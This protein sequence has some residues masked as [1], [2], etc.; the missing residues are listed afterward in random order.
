MNYLG[1]NGNSQDNQGQM[2]AEEISEKE[3]NS[4]LRNLTLRSS[5]TQYLKKLR[6]KRRRIRNYFGGVEGINEIRVTVLKLRNIVGIKVQATSRLGKAGVKSTESFIT[7]KRIVTESEAFCYGLI[8]PLQL[9]LHGV[10]TLVYYDKRLCYEPDKISDPLF[11]ELKKEFK[12]LQFIPVEKGRHLKELKER[13]RSVNP[14]EVVDGYLGK[15][16][17][18]LDLERGDESPFKESPFL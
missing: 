17:V 15:I 12:S 16:R 4:P 3:L 6:I 5:D 9:M 10:K 11:L 7:E 18:G 8:L 14:N 1:D 2:M 13:I